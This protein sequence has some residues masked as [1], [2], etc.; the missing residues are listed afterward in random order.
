MWSTKQYYKSYSRHTKDRNIFFFFPKTF[1][2]TI[3][4]SNS[5]K[6]KYK[7]LNNLLHMK[8]GAGQAKGGAGHAKGRN[9]LFF[10]ETFYYIIF[11]SNLLKTIMCRDEQSCYRS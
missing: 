9:I 1:Y 4:N 3:F 8:G 5:L 11:N 10:H 6:T 7:I 2:Y